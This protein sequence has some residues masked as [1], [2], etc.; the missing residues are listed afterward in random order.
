MKA[1]LKANNIEVP[2]LHDVSSLLLEARDKTNPSIKP[3]VDQLAKISRHLCRDREL[4]F[5][6]SE[7]LTP[8]DF[9]REEDAKEAFEFAKWVVSVC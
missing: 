2:Q 9:Y 6:G 3:H 1:I 4:A 8:S 7:D 5:Y